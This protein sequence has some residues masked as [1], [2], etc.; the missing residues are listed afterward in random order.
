MHI[1]L[2][3]FIAIAVIGSVYIWYNNKPFIPFTDEEIKNGTRKQF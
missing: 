1:A 2:Y 3:L